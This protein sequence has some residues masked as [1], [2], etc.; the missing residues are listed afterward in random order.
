MHHFNPSKRLWIPF[1][2]RPNEVTD[3]ADH[4]RF[5]GGFRIF[6]A[7]AL[8]AAEG[9]DEPPA[10]NGADALVEVIG[11]ADHVAVEGFGGVFCNVWSDLII[12]SDLADIDDV[13]VA[14]HRVPL[15]GEA[16]LIDE[17]A[18]NQDVAVHV[19]GTAVF[20]QFDF[21]K[22]ATAIDPIFPELALPQSAEGGKEPVDLVV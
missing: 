10:A 21:D 11:A 22:E 7:H 15:F 6:E 3:V 14:G 13:R 20:A 19:P 5:A 4:D 8:P 18:L 17:F 12:L 1:S 16:G 2:R 9:L